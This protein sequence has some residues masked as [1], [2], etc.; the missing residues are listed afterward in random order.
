MN[1]Q[2]ESRRSNMRTL[3]NWLTKT[4][5]ASFFIITGLSM[6][7]GKTAAQV[8]TEEIKKVQNRYV[9]PDDIKAAMDRLIKKSRTR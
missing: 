7:Q 6:A 9:V 2:A 5:V 1:G 4:V 8:A 3:P